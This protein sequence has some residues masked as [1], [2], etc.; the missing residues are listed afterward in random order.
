M[1]YV[2]INGWKMAILLVLL[3]A[4]CGR[5]QQQKGQ[6]V[7][8]DEVRLRTTPVKDQGRS[9]LCWIYA[10]LAT[11]ETEHLMQG[12]SVNLSPVFTARQ[13]LSRQAEQ[14]FLTKGKKPVSMRGMATMTLQLIGQY[15]AHPYDYYECRQPVNW[16]VLVRQTERMADG[17]IAQ[18]VGLARFRKRLERLL[19]ERLGFMP[20]YVHMLGAEYTSEQFGQSVCLDDEYEA[21]TSF[22]HHPFGE[23]FALEVADNQ[24][25][26]TFLNV[27]I[28]TLIATIDRALH[29]G[30]PV[31]W[32]GD[33]SEPGFSFQKGF[34]ECPTGQTS[35]Q[36]LRQR[37]FERFQTTDDHCM[38]L[39]GI[40]HDKTGKRYYIAKNSWGTG[41]PFGGFMYL[42]EDYVKM[43]TVCIVIKVKK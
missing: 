12:D 24:L 34:A 15:G 17:A 7:M 10:M 13:F 1:K 41:N 19:D 23:R 29:N 4:S 26:D 20:Q 30:H 2:T 8:I 43:K 42:S 16:H 18:R 28:D 22:T 37:Q 31:C 11:I 25:G 27:P 9:E 38:A 35:L 5:Q 21:L 32:E 40:A 14:Y 6:P 36:A 3:T 39:V 33:T